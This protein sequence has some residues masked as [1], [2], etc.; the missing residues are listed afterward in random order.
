MVA[1]CSSN[2]TGTE[3]HVMAGSG[4]WRCGVKVGIV[5]NARITTAFKFTRD[6]VSYASVTHDIRPRHPIIQQS[7]R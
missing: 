5:P 1:S 2:P 7:G 3:N 6:H 4:V